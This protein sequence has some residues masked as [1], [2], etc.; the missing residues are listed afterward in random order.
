MCGV[1]G[2]WNWRRPA[3]A[4]T[5]VALKAL[6]HRGKESAGITSFDGNSIFSHVGMG[7]IPQALP[8]GSLAFLPGKVAIGHTR[9]STTG[10]S[11]AENAQ[12]V[13]GFFRG[14]E[15]FVG[16]N[17]NLINTRELLYETKPHGFRLDAECSDT[18]VIA[19]L[20]SS[21]RKR[22]F[23]EAVAEV[24]QKLRG[25][26][27]LIFLFEGEVVAVRD[28]FGFHPLQLGERE[29][30][31]ITASESCVF[32]HLGAKFVKDIA[33]GEVIVID[34][35]GNIESI[36]WDKNGSLHIDI[37]EYI[38]F[39][40]PDSV[41]HGVEAGAARYLMGRFLA[42]EHPVE[43]DVII[44]IP[45][46]GNEAALGYYERMLERGSTAKFRPWALFRPH[47]VSRTFIEPVAALR[48]E[49]LRLK[50]NPRPTQLKGLR[51]AAIDDSMVRGTTEEVLSGLFWA[52]GVKELYSLKASPVYMHED[53]YGIDTYRIKRELIGKECGGD[54]NKILAE[55]KRRIKNHYRGC[56]LPTYLG[57][58][59]LD[60]T[61]RAVLEAQGNS[62]ELDDNSFYTG[63][64]TGI[65]PAGKGDFK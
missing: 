16:H 36:T 48:R 19:A 64:F 5:Y 23:K 60:A 11:S 56:K 10:G 54:V 45:D 6:Q 40:R 58:L 44:P 39:S 32:D 55:L 18:R 17:G 28:A 63:P 3:A 14:Q 4:D 24:L 49:Y 29:E 47:T 1:V 50:F 2:I 27:N 33:P 30:G 37:F 43:A 15:F 61:I 26:F 46:S 52:A 53:I 7:E 13:R 65:Y 34:S 8:P 9:Y 42:D 35:K 12:P 38:Y 51:V 20:I 59:S 21:S 57:Y 31:F 41:V 25:A 62:Q 22:E